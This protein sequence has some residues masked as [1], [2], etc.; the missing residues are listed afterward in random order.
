MTEDKSHPEIEVHI[1]NDASQ[2]V[3]RT[4]DWLESYFN[5]PMFKK[6][7]LETVADMILEGKLEYDM[8]NDTFDIPEDRVKKWAAMMEKRYW[9]R[10]RQG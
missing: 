9:S 1:P 4:A 2:K 8:D 10:K 3:K 5:G 7:I 6:K